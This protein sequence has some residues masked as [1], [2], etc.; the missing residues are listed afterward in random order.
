MPIMTWNSQF[1]TG[2][3]SIDKQH[4]Q[5]VSYVNELFDAMTA[6]KGDAVTKKVLG[7][8]VSYTVS[9]FAHEEQYFRKTRYPDAAAH[10]AEHEA[11][12]RQVG[13]FAKK[14]AA[15]KATVNAELM[16]FLRNWLATHILQSDKRYAAHLKANGA[17]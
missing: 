5:L 1:A 14:Y 11:L 7:D 3:D 15:G 12:K 17:T 16:N 9:H 10:T 6:N 2:I 13:D 4:Q 8:L